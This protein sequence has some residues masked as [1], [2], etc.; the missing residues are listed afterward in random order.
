TTSNMILT[1]SGRIVFVDFG[2][3]EQSV[4]LEARG[5]DLHLMRR[6]LASTHYKYA[7]ECFNAVI[8]GYREI[9]GD[10]ITKDVINKIREI[11]R[12]GRYI[13]GR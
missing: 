5:V 2:L 3:S 4:D 10:E 11:E 13:V 9:M 12:R 1:P 6:A 8:D 7:D